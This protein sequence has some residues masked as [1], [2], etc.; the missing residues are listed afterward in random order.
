MT[1]HP[2]L[3]GNGFPSPLRS[4]VASALVVLTGCGSSQS[5]QENMSKESGA[6]LN[7]TLLPETKRERRF[8]AVEW[9]PLWRR[10]GDDEEALLAVVHSLTPTADGVILADMG[11]LEITRFDGATGA[12]RWLVGRKGAGPGEFGRIS[13]ITVDGE[14]NTIVLDKAV[15]RISTFSKSGALLPYRPVGRLMFASSICVLPNG[16]IVAVVQREG[17][18]ITMLADTVEQRGYRFP[19]AIPKGAPEFA[20]AGHFARGATHEDCPVYTVFGYGLGALFA[21]NAEFTLRPYVHSVEPPEFEVQEG[22]INGEDVIYTTLKSGSV[23]VTRSTRWRD[24]VMVTATDGRDDYV[25]DLYTS[26]GEYLVSWKRPKGF[27]ISAYANGVLYTVSDNSV[28]PVLTAWRRA[29]QL[30]D[31]NVS[32]QTKR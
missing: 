30:A 19:V 31:H 9:E 3:I 13:E 27:E 10:G 11:T 26:R 16:S 2:R 18:W 1:G 22:T 25:F 32:T 17:T 28:A 5:E 29:P 23:A 4:I 14:D 24:T 20:W 15:G 7:S 12:T 6:L 21:D 8:E